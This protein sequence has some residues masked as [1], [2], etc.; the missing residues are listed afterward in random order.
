[1]ADAAKWQSPTV[2]AFSF[3]RGVA[4]VPS[5]DDWVHRAFTGEHA[6]TLTGRY[7]WGELEVAAT[8][9]GPDAQAAAGWQAFSRLLSA[10]PGSAREEWVRR[11]DG[12]QKVEA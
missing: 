1:M 10:V 5:D 11:D 6:V 3:R 12:W 8:A 4:E 2:V 7:E 9:T